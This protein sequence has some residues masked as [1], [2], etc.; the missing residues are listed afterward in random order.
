MG[1]FNLKVELPLGM[2]CVWLWR[3]RCISDGNIT[4]DSCPLFQEC[5]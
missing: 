3:V 1:K 2:D 4:F 5:S